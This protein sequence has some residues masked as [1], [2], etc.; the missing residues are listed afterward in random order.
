MNAIL[1]LATGDS[2]GQIEQI[3]ST[4][5][6]DW[7]QLISQIIS[8][9]IVCTLL[10][11]FAYKPVLKML[12]HRRDLIAQGLA[13]SE[14]IREELARTET[15]R[16]D[17]LAQAHLEASQLIAEARDAARRLREQET[18]KAVTAAAQIIFQAREVAASDHTRMLAQ[19]KREVGQ[20]VVKTVAAITGRILTAEDQTRLNE[21]TAKELAAR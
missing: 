19:L 9:A 6:V 18:Q 14:K 17:V 3:A 1:I 12:A 7:P 21:A 16:Q 2:G 4:F 8:F 10:Y 20:L 11:L 13:N 5:G 15:M